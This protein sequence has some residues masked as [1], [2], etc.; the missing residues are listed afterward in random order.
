M[1]DKN[2]RIELSNKI[3]DE[4]V[5]SENK[6]LEL[7]RNEVSQ[8]KLDTANLPMVDVLACVYNGE[9]Y[10]RNAIESILLQSYPNLNLIIVSDGCTDNT[11][12]II[13]SISDR[14]SNIKL[15][16]KNTNQ[17]L[18]KSLNEG[19]KYC[20]SDFIV[21]MDLDDLIHPLR[22]EKQ[23]RFLLAHPR[24]DVVSCFMIIFNEKGEMKKVTYRED[25]DFQKITLLFYSPL[26][27]AGSIF[28][29]KV[30]LDL[31]YRE[32]YIHAEDFDLWYRI[33]N[34]YVTAV[35]PEFLYLYRTHSNQVTNEKN[36]TVLKSSLQLI[37]RN[38]F[39]EIKIDYVSEDVAF[40]TDYFLLNHKINDEYTWIRYHNWLIKI[41]VCNQ[42]SGYF[43]QEKLNKFV[44]DLYWQTPFG[45][46]SE[47][48]SFKVFLEHLFSRI[49]N[50]SNWSKIKSIIK[51]IL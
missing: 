14:N 3:F 13:K 43:N 17:G 38:I 46:I 10:V 34:K 9:S 19:L 41:L 15:I 20:K 49:N 16:E 1:E 21:R 31:G 33:M 22:I 6:A 47:K 30:L 25:F 51:R 12:N 23:M 5:F 42:K 4:L 39:N 44:Y 11:V 50:Q 26:S 2:Y 7:W 27:H 29:S 28:R 48:L 18:I 45:E 32:E 40:H 37:M 36:I 35:V 8:L 24:I